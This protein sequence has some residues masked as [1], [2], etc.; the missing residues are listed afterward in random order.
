[1]S[2]PA[3]EQRAKEMG[4]TPEAEYKGDPAKFVDAD[5]FVERGEQV[6]PILRSTN[7]KLHNELTAVNTKLNSVTAALTE[8]QETIKELNTFHEETTKERVKAAREKL[9]SE[10]VEAKKGGDTSTEVQL[11]DELSRLNI[12]E[13][14]AAR[15]ATTRDTQARQTQQQPNPD[16]DPVWTG[17][18]S[19]HSWFGTDMRKTALA[20]GI[21]AEFRKSGDTTTGKPFLDKVAAEVNKTFG[22]GGTTILRGDKVEGGG[23]TGN[24]GGGGNGRSYADLPA[25]AKATATKQAA[26]FVGENKAFKDVKAWNDHYAAIYWAGE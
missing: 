3:V 12:A 19:E 20:N 10:L 25:D 1:M 9:M 6:L 14:E 5:T 22:Q 23:A 18:K 26:K 24:S 4:W 13:A 2:D 11:T 21:A 15:T 8:T 17:W 16:A 7:Q